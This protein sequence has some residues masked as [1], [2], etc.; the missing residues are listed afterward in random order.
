MRYGGNISPDAL[1]RRLI[2]ETEKFWNDSRK[3]KAAN[4]GMTINQV[5]TLA[6]R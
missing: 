2:Q 5:M 1:F 6:D 4:M 3:E